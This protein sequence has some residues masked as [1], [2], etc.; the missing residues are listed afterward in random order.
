MVKNNLLLFEGFILIFYSGVNVKLGL[1]VTIL[2]D[3]D[4]SYLRQ[5]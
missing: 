1:V 3:D 5:Q 4:N 2:S